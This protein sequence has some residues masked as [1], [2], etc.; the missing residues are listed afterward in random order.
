MSELK[1]IQPKTNWEG[2]E[3]PTNEDANRWEKNAQYLYDHKFDETDVEN[4]LTSSSANKL[5]SAAQGK[6]LNE[7]KAPNYNIVRQTYTG[8][9][10]YIPFEEFDGQRALK[11]EM[12]F[13]SS[14][15]IASLE[16]SYF[17][18]ENNDIYF[19]AKVN[20][21][22]H[23]GG[24][25]SVPTDV[26]LVRHRERDNV[27]S[28]NA[29]LY[30]KGNGWQNLG[31]VIIRKVENVKIEGIHGNAN[32]KKDIQNSFIPLNYNIENGVLP[33]S[34]TYFKISHAIFTTVS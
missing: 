5:L 15:G 20:K 14:N 10:L 21:H 18:N 6:E 13:I 24:V 32:F 17:G 4:T 1:W 33:S 9:E 8:N 22:L 25:F 11:V 23:D 16:I 29:E 2:G 31:G 7:I 12:D 19:E 3:T 27:F 28:E 34:T 26:Y 30:I